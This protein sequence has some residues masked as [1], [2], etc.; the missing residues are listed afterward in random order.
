MAKLYLQRIK[1]IASTRSLSDLEGQF[2]EW[3]SDNPQFKVKN[4][5][6]FVT[7]G[8]N[9]VCALYTIKDYKGVKSHGMRSE[10][11]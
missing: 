8:A 2:A 5:S 1:V 9:Y 11:S 3:I 6:Y 10:T 7:D 4:I